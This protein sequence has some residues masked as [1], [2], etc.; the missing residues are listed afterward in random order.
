M[1][2]AV[3]HKLKSR[4]G[5]TLIESL[6]AILVFTLASILMFSL[7]SAAGD[8]N[9]ERKES[10][11]RNQTHLIDLETG[12]EDLRNGTAVLTFTMDGSTILTVDADI[13]GG[14]EEMPFAYFLAPDI[15]AGGAP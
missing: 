5:E 2:N 13:Y 4:A 1:K 11:D 7:I 12:A 8:I 6:C 14:Q 15:G 9:A 3:F 10:D